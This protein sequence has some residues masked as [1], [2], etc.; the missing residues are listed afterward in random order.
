LVSAISSI[1][2]ILDEKDIKDSIR[3]KESKKK[4]I[5]LKMTNRIREELDFFFNKANKKLL[6]DF[7][8]DI[9]HLYSSVL[10]NNR[11]ND[12]NKVEELRNY[13]Y[14]SQNKLKLKDFMKYAF[15][16]IYYDS[17]KDSKVENPKI[18]RVDKRFFDNFDALLEFDF[19]KLFDYLTIPMYI[20]VEH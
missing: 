6:D 17:I 2:L 1:V 4:I 14:L 8:K 11:N 3:I 20:I 18:Q 19:R 5:F 9:N 13:D 12:K 7:T 10:V 15:N 16:G